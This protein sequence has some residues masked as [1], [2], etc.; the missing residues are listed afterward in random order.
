M[1]AEV[2]VK[3]RTPRVV[4]SVPLI[5]DSLNL[6]FRV[7]IDRVSLAIFSFDRILW[8]Q[9]RDDSVSV[10]SARRGRRTVSGHPLSTQRFRLHTT[11]YAG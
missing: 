6:S 10:L 2:R 7:H 4:R 8:G 9:L 5:S 11:V 1:L 3:A